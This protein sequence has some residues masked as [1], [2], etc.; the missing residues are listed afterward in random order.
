MRYEYITWVEEGQWAAHSPSV[1]GVYGV[2]KTRIQAV[3][4]LEEALGEMRAYLDEIGE[5][6]PRPKR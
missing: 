2:G 3:S 5:H 6:L 1:P 4:D